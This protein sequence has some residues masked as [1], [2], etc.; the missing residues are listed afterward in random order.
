MSFDKQE[1][2]ELLTLSDD[3]DPTAQMVLMHYST[4]FDSRGQAPAKP[5][6]LAKATGASEK[7]VRKILTQ[8]KNDAWL[9]AIDMDGRKG[10]RATIPDVL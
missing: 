7:A 3:M 10:Y 1:W 2:K 6:L 9:E 4:L 5:K 8:A